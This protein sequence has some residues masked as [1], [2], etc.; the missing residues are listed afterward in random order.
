MLTGWDNRP[1]GQR[2]GDATSQ[3]FNALLGGASDESL[4]GR[5]YRL[6]GPDLGL[7]DG[8]PLT[9]KRRWRFVR[10]AAELLFWVSD[11][12]RHTEKA[13]WKDVQRSDLRAKTLKR[14]DPLVTVPRWTLF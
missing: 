9:P 10:A 13:F 6:A 8:A 14:F 2:L 4:S 3:W 1:Y 11:R 5:S 7:R 12:G